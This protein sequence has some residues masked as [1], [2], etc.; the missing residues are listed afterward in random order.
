MDI[1]DTALLRGEGAAGTRRQTLEA[2]GLGVEQVLFSDDPFSLPGTHRHP[3]RASA[4]SK[5][6]VSPPWTCLGWNFLDRLARR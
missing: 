1:T 4:T 6:C 5:A 3:W 2:S